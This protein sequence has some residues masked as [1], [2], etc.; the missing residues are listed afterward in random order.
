[1][2]A[3][4]WHPQQQRQQQ[5]QQQQ[6]QQFVVDETHLHEVKGAGKRSRQTYSKYQTAVLET[7]FQ[8]SR[9]IVRNKRQQ[10][11]AELSLT[12]RQIKIWFQNR[13]MKE[14]KCHKEA[15]RIV[16]D[17]NV[18]PRVQGECCPPAALAS[19]YA[20]D[21]CNNAIELADDP[22]DD[23]VFAG[24]YHPAVT[25]HRPDDGSGYAVYGGYDLLTA[26]TDPYDQRVAKQQCWSAPV[27]FHQDLYGDLDSSHFQRLST[28][29]H[30]YPL[31]S[32]VQDYCPPQL[33]AAHGY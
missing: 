5:Q 32:Q 23:D 29:H 15:P 13:R 25:K 31:N 11:S 3:Y 2:S 18:Q 33:Q 26:T 21:Y 22:R 6:Q 7:V 10:M 9:Y 8:T 16:V 12:E 28:N 4:D 14:K 1:M 19:G 27:D 17:R 30:H 24:G 20:E